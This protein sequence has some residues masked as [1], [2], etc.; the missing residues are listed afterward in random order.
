MPIA[1][2]YSY[3]GQSMMN[4]SFEQKIRFGAIF[5]ALMALIAYLIVATGQPESIELLISSLITQ[6]MAI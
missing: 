5:G 3:Q 6:C 4:R 2:G 1:S